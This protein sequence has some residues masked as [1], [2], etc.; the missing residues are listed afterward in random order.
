MGKKRAS[1]PSDVTGAPGNVVRLE[2]FRSRAPVSHLVP[3]THTIFYLTDTCRWL[4]LLG[5]LPFVQIEAIHSVLSLKSKLLA[6]TPDLILV[7][8]KIGWEDPVTL[9]KTLTDLLDVPVV[10]IYGASDLRKRPS[11]LKDA[12][13]VGL[14]DT[15]STPLKRDE[16]WEALDV[17]LKFRRQLSST[18]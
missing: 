3:E 10:M 2:A 15:L 11:L 9:I 12:F 13:A 18:P 6:R 16:L 8:S 5:S 17:L 1:N 14:H 7:E 4:S